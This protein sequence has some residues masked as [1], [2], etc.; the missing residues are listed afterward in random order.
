MVGQHGM[1]H[2][3]IGGDMANVR[4]SPN[5]VAFWLH[6][7]AIDRVWAKWQE[8][9]P[10]ERAFL[11]GREARLDPWGSEFTVESI[12]NI[13]ALGDDSYAYEDPVRP[14]SPIGAPMV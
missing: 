6:H 11:S 8:R 3:W 1:G 2:A 14:A 10:D 12:D 5:D 13:G 9:N 4:H 7:A